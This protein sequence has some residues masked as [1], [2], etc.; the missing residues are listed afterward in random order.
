MTGSMHNTIYKFSLGQKEEAMDQILINKSLNNSPILSII[1][2][3]FNTEKYLPACLSSISKNFPINDVE[4]ILI[5]DCS[6]GDGYFTAKKEL[7]SFPNLIY[8]KK[9]RNEGLFAARISGFKLARGCYVTTLDSDDEF[10][11]IDW[12]KLS[13]EFFSNKYDIYSIEIRNGK[14]PEDSVFDE[15][16]CPLKSKE[17][18]TKK[19]LWDFYV[20]DKHWPVVGKFYRSSVIS[21]LCQLFPKDLPYINISEDFLGYSLICLISNSFKYE[22]KLGFYFYRTSQNSITR[23]GWQNDPQ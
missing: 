15:A 11:N 23:S 3:I 9:S 19:E 13:K 16:H 5:D 4:V 10:C 20:E 6:E 12:K 7:S 1:I 18:K 14:T 21:Q 2:P 17:C 8:L 22:R